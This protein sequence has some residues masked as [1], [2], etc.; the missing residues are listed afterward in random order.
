[1][2]FSNKASRSIKVEYL[3]SNFIQ[4]TRLSVHPPLMT[5]L[6]S[7]RETISN[8]VSS[9][10]CVIFAPKE[11]VRRQIS[12]ARALSSTLREMPLGPF[13]GP[14]DMFIETLP[15]PHSNST[16]SIRSSSPGARH[17]SFISS[18][19]IAQSNSAPTPSVQISR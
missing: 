16:C 15:L 2:Q 17:D 4:K 13:G 19:A 14:L 12:S 10:P 11:T 5:F 6:V 8:H 1:M 9:G 18:A 7:Y 3:A